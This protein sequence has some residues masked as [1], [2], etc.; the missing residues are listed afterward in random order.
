MLHASVVWSRMP[1]HCLRRWRTR[2]SLMLILIT[3]NVLFFRWCGV[4]NPTRGMKV[5]EE[6]IQLG[7]TP[8][9]FTY[10][11]SI[12]ALCRAGTVTNAAELFVFV[13]IKDSTMSS[14]TARTHATMIGALVRNNRM[15]ECF[16]LLEDMINNGC[17]PDALTYKELI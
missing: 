17:L 12:D 3:I 10:T 15:D 13:R 1:V 16:K 2:L 8:G 5:L 9:S 14:P 4:R 7:H 6:M 11:T